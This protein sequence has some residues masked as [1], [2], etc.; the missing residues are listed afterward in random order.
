MNDIVLSQIYTMKKLW[1]D[2]QQKNFKTTPYVLSANQ[3]IL[4]N[5]Q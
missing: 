1:L 5:A 2:M 4:S 3:M